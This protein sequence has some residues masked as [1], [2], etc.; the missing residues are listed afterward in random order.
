MI[1]Y[2]VIIILLM[3]IYFVYED[4]VLSVSKYNIKGKTN[5][6]IA[7][8]SDVHSTRICILKKQIINKIINE[9]VD[10]VVISGDLIDIR[11]K[12]FFK[13][14]DFIIEISKY[15][16]VY[17]APG[18]HDIENLNIYKKL[19]KIFEKNNI[20]VL[21]NKTIKYNDIYI[22]GIRDPFHLK[23]SDYYINRFKKK[24]GYNILVS[25]RPELFLKY[26]DKKID[27]VFTGHAHG[28]QFRFLKRGLYAPH[29]G[30][31]PKYTSGYFKKENTTMFVSRGIGNSGLILRI[32]NRPE[33]VIVNINK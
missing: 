27:M 5:L 7:H 17:F 28:G 3:V 21:D 10:I 12:N 33:L 29:Q 14:T 24:N 2:I 11:V 15:A 31:F 20:I 8:L 23:T 6:K 30:F 18:N 1:K 4:I 26:V 22:S 25:H 16:K 9:K 13:I 19:V 32:F